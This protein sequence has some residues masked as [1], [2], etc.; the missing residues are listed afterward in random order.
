V[1]VVEDTGTASTLLIEVMSPVMGTALSL[2]T[3]L[4]AVV[5]VRLSE[6]SLRDETEA[7]L[8]VV[9]S[10]TIDV[11]SSQ[12][13]DADVITEDAPSDPSELDTVDIDEL[14]VVSWVTDAVEAS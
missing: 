5:L 14:S 12:V 4:L 2:V 11:E 1:E 3:R 9:D 8:V 10:A 13:E 7:S 6:V